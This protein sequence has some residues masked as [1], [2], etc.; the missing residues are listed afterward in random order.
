M[1][2]SIIASHGLKLANSCCLAWYTLL[3]DPEMDTEPFLIGGTLGSVAS[4]KRIFVS[5]CV[6]MDL[7][8]ILFLPR[9][10]A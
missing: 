2:T 7:S 5:V 3:M 10:T 8:A 4:G 6:M 1:A 9:T